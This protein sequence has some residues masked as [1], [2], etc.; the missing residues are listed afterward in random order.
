MN[1]HVG[2]AIELLVYTLTL[3]SKFGV[4]LKR[5]L[6]GLDSLQSLCSIEVC[7]RSLQFSRSIEVWFCNVG[8]DAAT[9]G[10]RLAQLGDA[11]GFCFCE[12]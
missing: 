3:N 11:I 9:V 8:R 10:R 5:V 12:P 2:D 6:L 4:E 1:D 7:L